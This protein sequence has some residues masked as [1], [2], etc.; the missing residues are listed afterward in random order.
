MLLCLYGQRSSYVC[1]YSGVYCTWALSYLGFVRYFLVYKFRLPKC[2]R[3]AF[4]EY[5]RVG[6]IDKATMEAVEES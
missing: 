4:A 6:A 1:I 5:G 2:A 3:I